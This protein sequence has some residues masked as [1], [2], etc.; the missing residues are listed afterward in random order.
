MLTTRHELPQGFLECAPRDIPEVLDGP[1]LI[2]MPGQAG[3]P[4]FVSILLHGNEITGLLAIQRILKYYRGRVL[5][6]PL[7]LFVGN[8]QAA[9]AGK[10]L[11]P[12]QP[13]F[14]RIWAR[15]EGP[16]HDMTREV[17]DRVRQSDPV[18]CIDIHNNTGRNPMYTVVARQ[19]RSHLSLASRFSRTVVYA[20][21]P[22]TTCSAAFSSICPSVAVESGLPGEP[23]G[24]D[25]VVRLVSDSLE[26][27]DPV[28][29]VEFDID[30]FH[31]VAVVK[32]LPSCTCGAV[33]EDADIELDPAIER[34]NFREIAPGTRLA[35]VRSGN[36][37]CIEVQSYKRSASE[38]WLQV[39]DGELTVARAL[40]PA[41]LTSDPDIVK[42]DCLC[43][44][45]ERLQ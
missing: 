27:P 30:L 11:L 19:D 37:G 17:L 26:L 43:Y 10:R 38:S 13:D 8:V 28:H 15:G 39:Q 33:G 9:G 21:S 25:A 6:R 29:H 45:M 23:E 22:D 4:L 1:T 40:M 24:V 12:G 2:H 31:T 32:V 41:M 34:Y 7:W 3:R 36:S 16:E 44:L 20:T 5:P 18:A 35:R 42:W 14:N